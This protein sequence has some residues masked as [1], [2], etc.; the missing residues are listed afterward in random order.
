MVFDFMNKNPIFTVSQV[1]NT[2]NHNLEQ[3][4]SNVF[5]RGEISSFKTYDSGHAY[6]NLIDKSS[7]I[8][9]VYFNYKNDSS[10]LNLKE[11]VEVTVFGSIGLYKKRGNIQ[12]ITSQIHIGNEGE[13]WQDY[14]KLKDKLFKEGL[15]D[16]KH[17]LVLPRYPEKITIVSSKNGSV[18]HDMLNILNRRAPYLNIKIEHTVVQGVNASEDIIKVLK[19]VNFNNETDLIILARGGGSL[20][21][22]QPFNNEKVVRQIFNSKIP[23]ITAIGHE[24]D[25]T[26]SD[27]V[28]SLSTSTPSEA[29]EICAPSIEELKDKVNSFIDRI[30]ISLES[31]I[32]EKNSLLNTYY[33][34]I[35][36]KNPKLNIEFLKEKNNLNYKLLFNAIDKKLIDY[37]DKVKNFRE[38]INKYNFDAL[39]KRG[40]RIVKKENKIL[41]DIDLINIGDLIDIDF[42]EGQISATVNK[43]SLNKNKNE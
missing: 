31:V 21:D 14:L 38:I 40:F 15:F 3:N 1:T 9:C 26:L 25:L 28:S 23:L 32:V 37:N 2:L 42:N 7:L 13:L 41:K 30:E 27:F 17:K 12:L 24:T 4:F 18:I 39:G 11:N 36:S 35:L 10:Y 43:I 29:A 5:V 16:R 8:N 6:F 33:L 22:L 19:K 20:E 34:K